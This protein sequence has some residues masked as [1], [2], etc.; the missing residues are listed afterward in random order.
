MAAVF[1]VVHR[2]WK[3]LSPSGDQIEPQHCPRRASLACPLATAARIDIAI[4]IA[5]SREHTGR[6]GRGGKAAP[7]AP[8]I[9]QALSHPAQDPVPGA[10]AHWRRQLES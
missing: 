7:A 2:G 10:Y 8:G 6:G 1:S 5:A 3:D 9:P 4:D